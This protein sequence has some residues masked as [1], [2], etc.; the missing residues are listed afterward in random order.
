MQ[1]L[2]LLQV[3]CFLT[4]RDPVSELNFLVEAKEDKSSQYYDRKHCYS[5]CFLS[6]Q[7]FVLSIPH[8]LLVVSSQ[9]CFLCTAISIPHSLLVVSSQYC[10]RQ[11]L[12]IF[13]RGRRLRALARLQTLPSGRFGQERLM[14]RGATRQT[15]CTTS[16]GVHQE[17][18]AC[19][20]STA[21]SECF[22]VK[23]T[24]AFSQFACL[25]LL[26]SWPR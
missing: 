6:S 20:R 2:C 10:R 19:S 3:A 22:A 26:E 15:R 16:C 12:F 25:A 13:G 11:E 9:H 7:L 17:H 8:S 4:T 24:S 23:F 21:V 1:I 14:D 18:T 5:L